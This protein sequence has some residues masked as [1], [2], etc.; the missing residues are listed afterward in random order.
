MNEDDGPQ[1]STI[2]QNHFQSVSSLKGLHKRKYYHHQS[3]IPR[4]VRRM[5]SMSQR[6]TAVVQ[7]EEERMSLSSSQQELDEPDG[8]VA[9]SLWKKARIVLAFARHSAIEKAEAEEVEVALA[10]KVQRRIRNP[11]GG[12]SE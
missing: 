1:Q 10:P 11:D 12:G 8:P 2:V 6:Q 4:R 9:S 7:V 3:I 5:L